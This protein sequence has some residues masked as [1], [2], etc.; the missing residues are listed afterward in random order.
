MAARRK[1]PTKFYVRD[2][3]AIE[4]LTTY[5]VNHRAAVADQCLKRFVEVETTGDKR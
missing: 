3:N 5:G 2:G 1:R 4:S